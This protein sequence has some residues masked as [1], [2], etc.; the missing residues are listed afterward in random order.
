MPVALATPPSGPLYRV[1]LGPDPLLWPDPRYIGGSRFDDPL[2]QFRVLYV[3]E[4]RVGCFIESLARFRP[5]LTLLA[6]LAAVTGV[7]GPIPTPIVPADWYRRRTVGQLRLLPGQR[8]LDLRAPE[9]LQS[10]RAELAQTLVRLGLPDLDVSAARGPSRELTRQI[11]RW[12]YERDLQGVVYRSRFGDHVDCWAIF[13]GADTV[14]A[15]PTTPIDP[16]DGDL[17]AAARLF[18]LSVET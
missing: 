9:T 2:G 15:G 7:V 13:E 16:L 6:R 12:A 5:D 18:G 14:A 10:L 4:Q 11:A 17:H 1:A 3:A 8:W